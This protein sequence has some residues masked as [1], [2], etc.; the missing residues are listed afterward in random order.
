[1]ASDNHWI[2]R[3]TEAADL[4]GEALPGVPLVELSGDNRVLIEYHRGISEYSP[5]RISVRVKYGEVRIFGR[6]L[7]LTVM[8]RQ[9]LVISGNIDGMEIFRKGRGDC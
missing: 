1:M 7:T 9:C 4:Y 5:G 6:G 3:F 8:S 2:R